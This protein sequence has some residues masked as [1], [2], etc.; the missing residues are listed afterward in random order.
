MTHTKELFYIYLLLRCLKD[1]EAP[2]PL[3][4]PLVAHQS[5]DMNHYFK[6]KNVPQSTRDLMVKYDEDGNG[7]FSKDEVLQ[8]INELRDQANTTAVLEVRNAL[9]KR[10]L[11]LMIIMLVLMLLGVFGLTF[12]VAILTSK[13]DVGSD[14]TLIAINTGQNIATDARAELHIISFFGGAGFC[15]TAEE[16]R[17]IQDEVFSG[18]NVI[19]EYQK[20]EDSA[21]QV[22]QFVA[23]GSNITN[24]A[25]G[26]G[27]YQTPQGIEICVEKSAL[28]TQEFRR[29]RLQAGTG[30]NGAT[31][32]TGGD[33]VLY[34]NF[35]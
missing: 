7:V 32:G 16:S 24:A 9:Y 4:L 34:Y 15:A 18:K 5:E 23:S 10:L 3:P 12:A 22:V 8:I 27:C 19:L 30:G 20:D 35:P 25:A 1:E 14:G 29:R 2:A 6:R 21:K 11:L 13:L 33:E 26:E 31:G 17:M 28:C